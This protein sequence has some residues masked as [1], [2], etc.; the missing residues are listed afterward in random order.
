MVTSILVVPDIS[1]EHCERT[2]KSAL[3][4][5]A[6]VAQVEVSI[7]QKLVTVTYD[8][9]R[10]GVDALKAALAEEEYPV[11]AVR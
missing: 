9:S 8:T 7:P 2:V 1:C 10:V 4:K 11:A 6:G 3:G 5:L